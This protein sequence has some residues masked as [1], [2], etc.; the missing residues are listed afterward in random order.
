MA[1][2]S[3][4][5]MLLKATEGK[6]AV[7][8]FNVTNIVQMKA[9]IEAAQG[10]RA[11][12]IL[13]TSVAPVRFLGV[14]VLVAAYRAL[15]EAA[16]VPICLHLDHCTDVTL[17]KAAADAGYTNIM[18]DASK[19]EFE[20]NVRVTKA[21]TDYCHA[22]GDV[23]VEGELGTVCGVEDQIKV[24]EDEAALCDPGKAE[25]FVRR[26]G[27][28]LFAPAIGTAHGVYKTKN[29]KLRFD[30][31]QEV[32]KVLNGAEPTVP[33]VI[34]GGTGL[35]DDV[36]RR[37][38]ACGGCKFNVSTEL[39]HTLIDATYG[40]ISTHRDEYNPGRLDDAVSKATI[41][42]VER[43]IDVLGCAGKAG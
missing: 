5:K 15:A 40:Y 35:Q 11:P 27:I 32:F 37:L 26:S 8:A 43:W 24:T 29:P 19:E 13:Q 20:A 1:V 14:K 12:L 25:E 30:L 31:L 42:M 22:L 39:K 3:A 10:K 41:Q 17:C 33:L 28:D 2:V 18:I 6:Y 38:V 36:V 21:V 16:S 23:T 9:V 4:K 34:H 7:G